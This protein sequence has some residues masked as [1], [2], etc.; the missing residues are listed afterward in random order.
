MSYERGAVDRR[1]D[2]EPASDGAVVEVHVFESVDL[3]AHWSRLDEFE[4]P[5]YRRVATTVHTPSADVRAF[6]YVLAGP[7]HG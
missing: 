2:A 6:I 1:Q 7:E 5:G 3:P 4:G